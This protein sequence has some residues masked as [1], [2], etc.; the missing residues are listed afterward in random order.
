MSE[1]KNIHF[2]T[3]TVITGADTKFEMLQL[4]KPNGK[5]LA[6]VTRWAWYNERT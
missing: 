2:K 6:K 5:Y 4:N 1:T 3:S